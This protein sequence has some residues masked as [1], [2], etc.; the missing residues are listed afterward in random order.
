MSSERKPGSTVRW[1]IWVI[2]GLVALGLL[3]HR[4]RLGAEAAALFLVTTLVSHFA[5]R[6]T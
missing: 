5:R 3:L 1:R 4:P 6:K 2:L